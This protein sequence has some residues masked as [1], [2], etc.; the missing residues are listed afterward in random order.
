MRKQTYGTP[1]SDLVAN[2]DQRCQKAIQTA[3]TEEEALAL[4][5]S[6][7]WGTHSF[8]NDNIRRARKDQ[9]IIRPYLSERLYQ[10]KQLLVGKGRGG[11]WLPFLRE[12]G[13]PRSTADRY[14]TEWEQSIAPPVNCPTEALSVPTQEQIIQLVNKLK[15]KLTRVL[16]TP[17]FV[18]QFISLLAEALGEQESTSTLDGG[19]INEPSPTLP[20]ATCAL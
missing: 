20:D 11:Q 1:E 15:P 4:Q 13:I 3:K 9:A 14:V 2:I 7:L 6:E 18:T 12:N 10:Y 5:I 16:T 19:V 8:R 17:D